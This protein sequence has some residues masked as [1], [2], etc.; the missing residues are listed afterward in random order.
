[1]ESPETEDRWYV[2]VGGTPKMM[3]LDQ[4]VEAFEAGTINGKTLVTEVGGS[5]WKPLKEVADLGD[6][7]EPAPQSV[8]V[9]AAAAPVVAPPI[10]APAPK[11][12]VPPSVRATQ[13][14]WPPVVAASR[15]PMSVAPAGTVSASPSIAPSGASPSL[16]PVSTMPM[17]QDLGLSLDAEFKPRKSKAPLFAAAVVVVFIGGLFG[18]SRLTGGGEITRPIPVPAAAPVAANTATSNTLSA[19]T[20]TPAPTPAPTTTSDSSSTGSTSDKPASDKP[21]DTA[22]A[23]ARL[24]DDVKAKLKDADKSRSDKK[25]AAKASRGKVAA[26]SKGSSS[27][28]G[29]FRAGGNAND[30]LNSK[31]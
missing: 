23:D 25:K 7:E 2:N 26:R 4:I 8:R 14:G 19:T 21:S 29:V 9:P 27:S 22:S 1:M 5:E 24:A 11:A 16:A 3:N 17:V 20:S 10:A 12:S 28:S 18:V 30:P 13:S 15:A 6:D 31:L